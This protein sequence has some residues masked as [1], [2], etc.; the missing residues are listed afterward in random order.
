M[1]RGPA[2]GT[3]GVGEED[4]RDE[5]GR[6]RSRVTSFFRL[7]A[8]AVGASSAAGDGAAPRFA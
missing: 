2:P 6:E 7:L 3:T 5:A 4:G 1:G 8:L